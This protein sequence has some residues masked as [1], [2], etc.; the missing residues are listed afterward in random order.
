MEFS[1]GDNYRFN[2]YSAYMKRIFGE[3]VQKL[4]VDAGFTCPNRDGTK[5]TGGCTFCNNDAFNPSYCQPGKG[6]ALQL[7]EGIDFH[8]K[9]YRRANSY[10]AYFQAF[11][12]TYAS[13]DKLEKIYFEA[14][15]IEGVKGLVIGTRPDCIDE[16]KLDLLKSI[17]KKFTVFIEFGV[18]SCNDITLK[19]INRGHSFNESVQAIER[20]KAAGLHTGAHFI[21]GLPGESREE[22]LASARIISGLSLDSVKF[23]QLQI[24]KGTLMEKEF[25]EN[26]ENF[27]I[28]GFEEYVDFF[29]AFIEQMNPSIVVERFT[30]EAPPNLVVAP[31]WG[32]KRNDEVMRIFVKRLFE[33]ETWQGR[34]YN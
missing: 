32:K 24:I 7:E 10:L 25:R 34:L 18:E 14:L 19:R 28:F 8:R 20:S 2:S 27:E 33:R 1:W 26:P 12:N 11:S 29:V 30:S 3:R 21:F 13:V 6:I 4:S 9:R 23:H 5:G 22:M 16:E 17:A 15:G 31:N